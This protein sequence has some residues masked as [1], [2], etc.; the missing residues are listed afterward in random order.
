MGVTVGMVSDQLPNASNRP[1]Y[2][3]PERSREGLD[4]PM[5]VANLNRLI[6]VTS[7]TLHSHTCPFARV[8]AFQ[9]SF[10]FSILLFVSLY[11]V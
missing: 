7:R 1:L 6:I 4:D 2:I 5:T 3:Q 9:P 11:W 10:R 8:A